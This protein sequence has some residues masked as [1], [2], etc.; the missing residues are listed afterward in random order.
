L[1]VCLGQL[2]GLSKREFEV[3]ETAAGYSPRNPEDVILYGAVTFVQRFGNALNFNIHVEKGGNY[4]PAGCAGQRKGSLSRL[5]VLFRNGRQ[6][7]EGRRRI[8]HGAEVGAKPNGRNSRRV[9]TTDN[10]DH[11]GPVFAD[12]GA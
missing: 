1:N 4:F 8:W 9:L 2:L 10:L 6:S 3:C 12:L 7:S 5:R 11:C